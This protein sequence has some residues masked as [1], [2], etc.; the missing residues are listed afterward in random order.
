MRRWL[1]VFMVGCTTG[2]G[3]PELVVDTGQPETSVLLDAAGT[4]D[5]GLVDATSLDTT[6]DAGLRD[7]VLPDSAGDVA[8][9]RFDVADGTSGWGCGENDKLCVCYDTPVAGY[10]LPKC[11]A[12][13][14]C[15]YRYKATMEAGVH[16][17][18]VCYQP[19]YLDL[20]GR[21]C[22]GSGERIKGIGPYSDVTK[23]SSCP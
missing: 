9:A 13:Y 11:V 18:C 14:P 2:K 15:C 7:D 17:E 19:A 4:D 16:N 22:A 20:L 5:T 6:S 10:V 3:E 8:D 23:V 12:T 1:L 21:D